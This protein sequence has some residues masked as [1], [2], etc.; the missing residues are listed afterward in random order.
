M[1]QSSLTPVSFIFSA[2]MSA[3]SSRRA[4]LSAK[5]LPSGRTSASWK[6]KKGAPSSENI[7]KATSALSLAPLHRVAEP[8]PL[9]GLAAERVAARPGEGVPVGDGEA[10]MVFH[11]LAEHQL[12]WIVEAIGERVGRVRPLVLDWLDVA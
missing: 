11:P 4:A 10:Q 6:Q 2:K 9:E 5:F 3:I 7:S 8:R 1:P 12:V